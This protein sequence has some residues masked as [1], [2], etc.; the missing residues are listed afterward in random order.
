MMKRV[1]SAKGVLQVTNCLFMRC[2]RALVVVPKGA[3][4]RFTSN[5]NGWNLGV[6]DFG[7]VQYNPRTWPDYQKASRQDA[8]SLT[9]DPKFPLRVS[10]ASDHLGPAVFGDFTLPTDSPYRTSSEKGRRIGAFSRPLK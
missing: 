8:N 5:Y 6:V 7:R 3:E 9:A 1:A 4:A 2:S 10:A